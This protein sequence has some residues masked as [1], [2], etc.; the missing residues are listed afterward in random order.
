MLEDG[1]EKEGVE[2]GRV[3]EKGSTHRVTVHLT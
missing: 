3:E 2:S 1:L